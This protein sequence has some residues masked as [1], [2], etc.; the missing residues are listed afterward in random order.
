MPITP[1][2]R[3]IVIVGTD[4]RPSMFSDYWL[5]TH[6]V[7]TPQSI[8]GQRVTTD[9][10]SNI[11]SVKFEL[12]VVPE[13]LQLTQKNP[14]GNLPGELVQP[15]LKLVEHMPNPNYSAVGLNI[16]NRITGDV[17]GKIVDFMRNQFGPKASEFSKIAGDPDAL[18]SSTVIK[19]WQHGRCR[20][21]VAPMFRE[22]DV[23]D[24][25]ELPDPI[26]ISVDCN[27]NFSVVPEADRREAVERAIKLFSEATDAAHK[28]AASVLD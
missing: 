15:A 8:V 25:N 26:G 22:S 4:F 12:M 1:S 24:R 21:I 5:I 27:F 17:P 20:T 18:W 9:V 28:I 19:S 11:S 13:R 23:N 16:M 14:P 2:F 6:D 3:N 10:M 7:A